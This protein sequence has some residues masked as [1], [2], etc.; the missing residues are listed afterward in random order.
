MIKTP[1]VLL[2]THSSGE[3][4]RDEDSMFLNNRQ[5]YHNMTSCPGYPTVFRGNVR[6]LH[7]DILKFT[8]G[9]DILHT[10]HSVWHVPKSY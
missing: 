5:S 1:L 3:E 4:E 10:S 9:A 8:D 7:G 2:Y 6:G